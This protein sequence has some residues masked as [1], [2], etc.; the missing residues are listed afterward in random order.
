MWK[1]D[2]NTIPVSNVILAFGFFLKIVANRLCRII[3]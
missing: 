1:S 3:E 2:K